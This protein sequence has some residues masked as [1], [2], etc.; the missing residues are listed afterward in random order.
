MVC[1]TA[2]TQYEQRPGKASHPTKLRSPG[3]PVGTP[4]TTR[5]GFGYWVA[6]RTSFAKSAMSTQG[7]GQQRSWGR[8]VMPHL[9][10]E[11]ETE[12]VFMDGRRATAFE[13]VILS[14]LSKLHDKVDRSIDQGRET[15]EDLKVLCKEIGIDGP[16][17]RLPIVEQTQANHER[18]LAALETDHIEAGARHKMMAA[19]A[20]LLGGSV[21][22]TFISLIVRMVHF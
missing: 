16:H 7:Y 22:G 2:L 12:N 10:R 18:R 14:E 9:R 15:S 5:D 19:A 21:G 4:G 3:I 20:S 6:W 1:S 17:G 11:P 8:A 13:T